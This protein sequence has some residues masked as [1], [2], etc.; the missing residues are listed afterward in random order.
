MLSKKLSRSLDGREAGMK[1]KHVSCDAILS[2]SVGYMM[3]LP[4]LKAFFL[5]CIFNSLF[6]ESL[7]MPGRGVHTGIFWF[8]M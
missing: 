5:S 6:I 3:A 1:P 8:D 4:H 2:Q 7:F